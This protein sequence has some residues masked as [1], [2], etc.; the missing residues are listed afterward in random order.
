MARISRRLIGWVAAA[1]A[2]GLLLAIATVFLVVM[3]VDPNEHKPRIEALAREQIGRDLRLTGTLSWRIAPWLVVESAGGT[4]SNPAGF[5]GPPFAAWRRLR[6]GLRLLPLLKR[7]FIVDRI[8]ID[9]LDLRLRRNA[10]GQDNWSFAS[11]PR[12]PDAAEP[13]LQVDAL[14]LT[15][16]RV[17]FEDD[18][19]TA[20]W[21]AEDLALSLRLPA[22]ATSQRVQAEK[23]ELGARIFGGSLSPQGLA[24]AFAA[25]R[26][27]Y[28]GAAM[29]VQL[30]EFK[31]KLNDAS[32]NGALDLGFAQALTARGKVDVATPRLRELLLAL[33]VAVPATRDAGV[34]R[35]FTLASTF[36]LA[37]DRFVTE[38]L[39][40]QMD[41]T[42]IA[43]DLQMPSLERGSIRFDL[44]GD[45][46]DLDRYLEPEG[47]VSKPFE[48]QL[49]QLKALDAA[50][51]LTFERAKLGGIAIVGLTLKVE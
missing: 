37:T 34:I 39:A 47:T 3:L 35:R 49:A 1:L 33:G 20:H 12:A 25:P 26:V 17:S 21:R 29:S 19:K 18:I 22:G 43:G 23:V 11:T 10:A 46:I 36:T 5:A 7:E 30:A 51:Q 50:G 24:V 6:L 44:K 38:G 28:D 42:R 2:A 48:L 9:G 13:R 32:V 41:E 15:H 4:L 40:V 14:E 8:A 16:A 31:A 45:S 27:V